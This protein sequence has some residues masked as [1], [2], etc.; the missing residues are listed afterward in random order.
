MRTQRASIRQFRLQLG[1]LFSVLVLSCGA[2]IAQESSDKTPDSVY[3]VGQNGVTAPKAIYTPTPEYSEKARR[4]KI[5][6][7]VVVNML[8][9]PDGT[10]RDVKIVKSLEESLDKQAIA[11]VSTW[12]F[13]PATKD[14]AP[15]AVRI[16]VEVSFNLR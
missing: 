6:G 5:Q 10:V 12:K 4:K 2:T 15:V 3:V 16:P 11:A 8:V 14:G 13:N 9:A 1:L 7:V